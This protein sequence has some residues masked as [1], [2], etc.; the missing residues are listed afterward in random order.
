MPGRLI[1]FEGVD[2]TG[3]TTQ[4]NLLAKKLREEGYDLVVTKEP[5]S[6][7]D[8]TKLGL[9][10]RHILFQTVTTHRMAR[11]VADCLLL[12]DHIQHVAKVVEPALAEGKTVIS[13]RYADSEFAY[14]VA[15]N[16]PSYLLDAYTAAFGPVPEITVL[17]IAEDVST[18]LERARARRGETHQSGKKWDD[19]N[20]QIA[21]QR[22]YLN[23]LVGETR[24]IVLNVDPNKSPEQ[25]FSQ[26]LWPAVK[27]TM[28]TQRF[29]H[30]EA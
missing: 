14:A 3:K 7:A 2:G 28:D 26:D 20:Q 8:E 10:L 1:T 19:V 15:K 30:R 29:A 22:E 4:I 18:M 9:E 11:G 13:D 24:T 17:F 12:A 5:G 27:F 16:T 25:I 23:R 6:P 21:I